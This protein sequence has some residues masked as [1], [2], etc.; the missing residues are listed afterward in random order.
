[1]QKKEERKKIHKGI[2]LTAVLAFISVLL[3]SVA[4]V[5]RVQEVT[6]TGNDYYTNEQ[7]VDF[8]IEDGYKRNTLYL[9][10]RYKYL[11]QPEITLRLKN[12][13]TYVDGKGAVTWHDS[14][15]TGPGLYR[16][17]PGLYDMGL[18]TSA[19]HYFKEG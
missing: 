19:V 14:E 5:F 15:R 2:L 18:F 9:Y 8:V 12:I 16:N 3:L 4:G 1:M 17:V 10:F 13:A 6:V 7:I 11:E